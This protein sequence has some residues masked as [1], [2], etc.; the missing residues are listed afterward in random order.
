MFT[1]FKLNVASIAICGMIVFATITAPVTKM[2]GKH[3]N[4]TKDFVCCKANQLVTHH[5]FTLN[6][7]WIAISDG[8]TLENT[9]KPSPEGCDIKC[10]D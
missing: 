6:V 10:K 4:Q 8:F 3:Y 5:Y 1:E 2:F 7:F 9:G